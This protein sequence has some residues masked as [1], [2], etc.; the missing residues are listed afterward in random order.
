MTAV[1]GFEPSGFRCRERLVV[2][3]QKI[4]VLEILEPQG[5]IK[6]FYKFIVLDE[7]GQEIFR[8][9]LGSYEATNQYAW[10]SGSLPRD[11]RLYH[12]DKYQGAAHWT[13]SFFTS[14][15][16]YDS[17]RAK[18]VEALTKNMPPDER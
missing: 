5:E 15:P 7:S 3:G 18:V 6:I 13:L 1:P 16:S 9:T 4:V 14:M 2:D 17:I 8:F 12:L 11:Q 10:E